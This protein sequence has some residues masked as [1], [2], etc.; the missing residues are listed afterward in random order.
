M[1]RDTFVVMLVLF[2]ALFVPMRLPPAFAMPQGGGAQATAPRENEE[3]RQI[4]EMHR[5]E[6]A[7][8]PL[9]V[10][11]FY[12]SHC[13]YCSNVVRVINTELS[14]YY[15]NRV[16]LFML[17]MANE[18]VSRNMERLKAQYGI[19]GDVQMLA[20]IGDRVLQGTNEILEK[21]RS[22]VEEELKRLDAEQG[23]ASVARGE[24]AAQP[25]PVSTPPP[26]TSAVLTSTPEE[27]GGVSPQ[28]LLIG[29]LGVTV[30]FLLILVVRL[31]S[32]VT[33]MAEALQSSV[34]PESAPG[35]HPDASKSPPA[36]SPPK[37]EA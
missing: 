11:I 21:T 24:E 35:D 3:D 22:V 17:D 20:L 12:L 31:T 13:I 5:H 16:L 34:P 19:S 10:Q 8:P 2:G 30:L 29:I 9:T 23:T 25:T 28:T 27:G 1:R 15:G 7:P 4:A 33:R 26:S 14:E 18:E 32:R 37:D 6:D 36:T